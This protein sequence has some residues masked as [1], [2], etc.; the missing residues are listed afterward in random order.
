MVG[1]TEVCR[2]I[3]VLAR[4]MT[5]CCESPTV[6]CFRGHSDVLLMTKLVTISQNKGLSCD[7]L[8]NKKKKRGGGRLD[9]YICASCSTL[10]ISFYT[11]I[12]VIM[13]PK[14]AKLL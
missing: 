14:C 1:I 6:S 9:R 12:L 13:T 2:L 5:C 3:F 11:N 8:L 4:K 10:P 7:S